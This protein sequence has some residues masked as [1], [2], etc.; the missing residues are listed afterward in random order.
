MSGAPLGTGS[1]TPREKRGEGRLNFPTLLF[2]QGQRVCRRPFI[3][4]GL[5]LGVHGFE[6][7]DGFLS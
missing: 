7:V 4:V 5:L 3:N 1:I 2:N 6:L